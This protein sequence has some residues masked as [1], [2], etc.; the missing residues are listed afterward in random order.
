MRIALSY[1]FGTEDTSKLE[2]LMPPLSLE[3]QGVLDNPTPPMLLVNG[4]HDEVWP[5]EDTFLLLERGTP[6]QAW[7][8][9]QAYTW[10][11]RAVSGTPGASVRKSSI[12]GFCSDLSCQRDNA[13]RCGQ[14]CQW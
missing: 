11:A 1:A 6:K 10:V 13:S 7:V 2:D 14:I 8:N 5:I 4:Y 9:P 3:S 12:P